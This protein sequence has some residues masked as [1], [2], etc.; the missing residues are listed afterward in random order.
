MRRWYMRDQLVIF[1][2]LGR[3][4]L[5]GDDEN[6]EEEESLENERY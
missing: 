1:E 4:C 2:A 5:S 3:L 6:A